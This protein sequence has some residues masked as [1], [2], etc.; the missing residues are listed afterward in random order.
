MRPPKISALSG[1]EKFEALFQFASLGI[2]IVNNSG[3]I[4]LANNFLLNQ[5]GYTDISEL[6]GKKIEVL[7]PNRFHHHHTGYR[8]DYITHPQARPMG[9]GIDLFAVK[10]SG[11]EFPVEVSLSNYKSQDVNF[12]IA[13]VNDISRRKE[14][15]NAVF[16]PAKRTGGDQFKN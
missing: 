5:F 10:K 15:E 13:F 7:I 9:V 2:L 16:R 8:E 14:I 11:V 12:V 6:L 4:I 3:E 1:N